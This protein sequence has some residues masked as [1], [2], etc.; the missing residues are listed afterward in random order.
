MTISRL[1]ME[2]P[3]HAIAT[4]TTLTGVAPNGF[5]HMI[6][7]NP[8]V[9]D[10]G[11]V[12]NFMWLPKEGDTGDGRI[13]YTVSGVNTKMGGTGFY[14]FPRNAASYAGLDNSGDS[15]FERWPFTGGDRLKVELTNDTGTSNHSGRFYFYFSDNA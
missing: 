2:L 8:T 13:I 12:A 4:K 15:G 10:T 9:G 1:L 3:L 11:V 7:F 5:L 6:Q 14:D